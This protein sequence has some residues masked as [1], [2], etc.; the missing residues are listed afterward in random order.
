M[1]RNF[2]YMIKSLRFF[3][4]SKQKKYDVIFY[5]PQHFNRGDTSE[6]MYFK[7]LL[8]SCDKHSLSYLVFEEPDYNSSALRDKNSI[9]FDFIYILIVILRRFFSEKK[10]YILIDQSIGKLISNIF[11][12]KIRF[13]NFITL[14][15]SMLSFFRGVNQEA[16]LYDLQHGILYNDKKNYIYH[17]VPDANLSQNNVNLLLTGES[18]KNILIGNER[19]RFFHSNSHVIGS[20]LESYVSKHRFFN[21]RVLVTLQFTQDHSLEQNMQLFNAI[22]DY[23]LSSPKEIEFY[24]K[25]HPRS[26]NEIDLSELLKLKN[27]YKSPSDINK[28]FDL[29]SLHITVYSTSVFEAAMLEIPSIIIAPLNRLNF[30]INEFNYPLNKDL[31]E[32]YDNSIYIKSSQIVRKWAE[33]YYSSYNEN[34]FIR[35]MR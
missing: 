26:S 7:H 14:S 9:P 24:L 31:I 29:C 17:G 2:E 33:R 19:N 16:R 4:F 27:V 11:F 30:F 6:N 5:Y 34:N 23:I 15:Q 22:K 35:L 3:L 10:S 21:K 32:Y 25:D 18:Y 13:S 1:L 28:A 12:R 20:K 8:H